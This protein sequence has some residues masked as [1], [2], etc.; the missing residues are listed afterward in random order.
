M[1]L[2][3]ISFAI[4]KYPKDWLFH[5]NLQHQSLIENIQSIYPAVSVVLFT[6]AD[7]KLPKVLLHCTGVS[8]EILQLHA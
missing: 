6:V 4:I 3:S 5:F 8:S 7:F 1:N 2:D